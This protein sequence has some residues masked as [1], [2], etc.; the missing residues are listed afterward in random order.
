MTLSDLTQ[1]VW[2]LA[3]IVV[4]LFVLRKVGDDLRPI[5]NNVVNGLAKNAQQHALGYAMAL[6]LATLG[7]LQALAEVAAEFHW[8]YV[9]AFAKV[10]QPGLAAIVGYVIK[11]PAF[12]QANPESNPPF[13]P[14]S[15]KSP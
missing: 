11:P 5:A 4:A 15:P 14:A 6:L 7:S 8:V 9:G 2:P 12:T 1:F 10:M 3:A 13:N